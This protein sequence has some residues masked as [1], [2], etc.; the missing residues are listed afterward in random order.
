MGRYI[1]SFNHIMNKFYYGYPVIFSLLIIFSQCKTVKLKTGKLN[2]S[3]QG[4][5]S[6]AVEKYGKHFDCKF[7]KDSTYV[8]CEKKEP[9]QSTGF[10]LHFFA[11]DLQDSAV[12]YEDKL[13]SGNANWINKIEIEMTESLGIPTR[14]SPEG[15]KIR[16]LNLQTMKVRST[17]DLNG[18]E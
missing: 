13:N 5:R 18:G 14:Q 7:N 12:V 9:R 11:F 10:I 15:F 17:T 16:I 4:Y 2:G 6:V 8:L 1:L 3:N